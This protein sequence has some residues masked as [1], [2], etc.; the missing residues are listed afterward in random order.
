MRHIVAGCL[1]LVASSATLPA[2]LMTVG[3][4][5]TVN[6]PAGELAN[7]ASTGFGGVMT[8][9]YALDPRWSVLSG[10]SLARYMGRA[11]EAGSRRRDIDITGVTLGARTFLSS[12][13]EKPRGP[14]LATDFG[15]Y[16]ILAQDAAGKWQ[17]EETEIGLMPTLGY[18]A[19]SVDVSAQL[20]FMGRFQ[21]IQLG[22][23]LGLF[24]L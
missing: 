13:T 14:Y 18:R 15:W 19:G 16:R 4:G 23:S 22:A 10:L 17:R 21:W 5:A 24:R 20:K 8:V 12:A 3:F 2:Q 7:R 6:A 11:P 1:L 9:E